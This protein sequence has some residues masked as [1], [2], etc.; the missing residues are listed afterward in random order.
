LNAHDLQG[1]EKER[2]ELTERCR[3]LRSSLSSAESKLTS[4]RRSM[5]EM[6]EVRSVHEKSR[7]HESPVTLEELQ[8]MMER[9]RSSKERNSTELSQVG[10]GLKQGIKSLDTLEGIPC[11]GKFPTCR[12]ISEASAFVVHREEMERALQRLTTSRDDIFGEM[13]TLEG[14]D[15]IHRTFREWERRLSNLDRECLQLERDASVQRD[16]VL[17]LETCLASASLLLMERE[18]TLRMSS[19][20]EIDSLQGRRVDLE[21][22]ID[23]LRR[24]IDQ[25]LRAIGGTDSAIERAQTEL[26]SLEGLTERVR[27]HER[28]LEMC[29]K[30][31]LPYRILSLVLPVINAEIAKIL[32]GIVK[33]SVFFEADPEEQSVGLFVRYGDYRSRP[34]S[35][36]SGAERFIAS[37]AVRVA[38]L[39][40][41]SLPKTDVLIID[42]GFGRLDPE[43][44]ES[45]QRMFEY[46]RNAFR[47]V[48]VVSHVDSMRDMVDHSIEI[49]S[50]DGYAHVEVG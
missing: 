27:A 38:L 48:F 50:R 35:L 33:F 19:V 41:S 20:Q 49:T 7:P 25:S 15:V 31:G 14:Y 29:G 44:L 40:V 43:H 45:L 12:F 47:S 4:I 24:R 42:E 32:S 1:I 11:G 18:L 39:S 22:S 3:V 46:L 26:L 21:R 36:G 8:R 30:D 17:R 34:M 16:E 28:L 23:A 6:F 5:T 2:R 37:L 13:K 9:V 10:Y